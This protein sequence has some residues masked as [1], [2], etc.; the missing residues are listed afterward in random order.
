MAGPSGAP[1]SAG[2]GM[3]MIREYRMA[4]GAPVSAE[5]PQQI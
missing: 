1:G 5:Q 2:D 3:I 4:L